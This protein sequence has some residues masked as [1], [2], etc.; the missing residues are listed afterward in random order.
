M[1]V[2]SLFDL[3]SKMKQS[4]NSACI[5]WS[6]ITKLFCNSCIKVNQLDAEILKIL[7]K[8]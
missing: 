3:D 8:I 6:F 7:V 5:I 4:P 1:V 2:D